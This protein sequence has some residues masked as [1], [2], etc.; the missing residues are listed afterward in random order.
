MTDLYGIKEI[1]NG[2]EKIRPHNPA[3]LK[4]ETEKTHVQLGYQQFKRKY[5]IPGAT[6]MLICLCVIPFPK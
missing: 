2:M 6:L 4:K 1:R 5:E 3:I